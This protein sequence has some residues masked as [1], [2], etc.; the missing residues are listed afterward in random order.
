MSETPEQYHKRHEHNARR[1]KRSRERSILHSAEL[2][3]MTFD[4]VLNAHA[5]NCLYESTQ[6]SQTHAELRCRCNCLGPREENAYANAQK[7]LAAEAANSA[8]FTR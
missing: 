4:E 6:A 8:E 1:Q 2:R 5:L 7:R 3:G